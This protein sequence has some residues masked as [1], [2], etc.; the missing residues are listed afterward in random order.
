MA[1]R[2]P[3]SPGTIL[4]CDYATGFRAPE[5]VKRRP[6]VVISPHLRHRDRLCSVVVT[7]HIW[8]CSRA[9]FGLRLKTAKAAEPRSPLARA[10]F[11]DPTRAFCRYSASLA[12][13]L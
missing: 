6:A 7:A 1:I 2:F 5:M 12:P 4:L 10:G 8:V 11:F 9:R 13:A 3:V